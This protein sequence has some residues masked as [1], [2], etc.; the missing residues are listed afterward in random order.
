MCANSTFEPECTLNGVDSIDID[1]SL[2]NGD[3]KFDPDFQAVQTAVNNDIQPPTAA[4]DICTVPTVITVPIKGPVGNN[5]C[6]PQKKKVKLS[7]RSEVIDGRIYKDRDKIKFICVPDPNGCDPLVLFSS[8]FDRIQRQVFNQGCAVSGCHDS[9]S[10]MGDLL[11]ETGAAYGQLLN[12]TPTN[13]AADA[14]NWLRVDAPNPPGTSGTAETSFLYRKIEGDLPDLSY[15]VRMPFGKRKLN[16]T[17]RDVIELWI[18]AGA[19]SA[20]WVPGTF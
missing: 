5:R 10:Q 16:K 8:T 20:G 19:P 14:A 1:N 4:V 17:L 15:G 13:P 3:P 12:H 6:G 2:D 11:L 7:A 9:Q 18:E